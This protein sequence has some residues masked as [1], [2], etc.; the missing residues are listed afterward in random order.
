VEVGRLTRLARRLLSQLEDFYVHKKDED[1]YSERRKRE[2]K[3]V[4]AEKTKRKLEKWFSERN[5][6]IRFIYVFVDVGADPDPDIE[7]IGKRGVITY[8]YTPVGQEPPTA[9]MIAHNLSHAIFEP[10][11]H[12]EESPYELPDQ[13]KPTSSYH[14]EWGRTHNLMGIDPTR[15]AIYP[16]TRSHKNKKIIHM[17]EAFHELFAQ[18]VV[19]GKV[20]LNPRK[21]ALEEQLEHEFRGR[22][23]YLANIGAVVYNV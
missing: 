6:P 10:L 20:T 12:N 23:D 19:T 4:Q 8:L 3:V 21:P 16:T 14:V 2:L 17:G 15:P 22:I 1:F 13:L 9:W 7:P 18:W 11:V 5:I